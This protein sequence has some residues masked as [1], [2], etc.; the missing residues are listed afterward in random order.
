[1]GNNIIVII[2]RQVNYTK[3]SFGNRICYHYSNF[4]AEEL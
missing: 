3:V 1:M 4:K 2:S